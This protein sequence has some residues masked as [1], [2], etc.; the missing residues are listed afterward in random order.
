MLVLAGCAPKPALPQE[1]AYWYWHQGLELEASDIIGLRALGV[2]RMF[3]RAATLS[4]DGDRLVA[5]MPQQFGKGKREFEIHLVVNFDAGAIRHFEEV[6]EAEVAKSLYAGWR[7]AAD[8]ATRRGWKVGGMQVDFDCPTR[9]LPRYGRML[10]HLKDSLGEQTLSATGLTSWIRGG[11]AA[12]IMREVDLFIP[13]FYEGSLPKTFDA[14]VPLA[15][16]A[17]LEADLEVLDKVGRPYMVGVPA[18]GQCLIFDRDDRLIGMQPNLSVDAALTSPELRLLSVRT[19]GTE[20]HYRLRAVSGLHQG[21]GLLYRVCQPATV[22]A[23]RSRLR[24]AELRNCR[25]MA[26]YRFPQRGESMASDLG[27]VKASLEHRPLEPRIQAKVLDR[28]DPWQAIETGQRKKYARTVT[29]QFRNDGLPTAI[30]P[31][32]FEVILRYPVGRVLDVRA[33][34]FVEAQRLAPGGSQ[35]I[36]VSLARSDGIVFHRPSLRAETP[37][38]ISLTTPPQTPITVVWR[39][40]AQS[41]SEVSGKLRIEASE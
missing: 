23:F 38:E 25:G 27:S 30:A 11:D 12:S 19:V 9:L 34:G 20:K 21:Y 2:R 14:E 6:P 13:Q 3:V 18:Y 26:I 40:M 37:A 16:E 8:A 41:G 22:N 17:V 4:Y 36:E 33:D 1:T 32:A 35:P 7:S 39:A 24:A 5:T 29:V 10:R 31:R 15:S 28:S